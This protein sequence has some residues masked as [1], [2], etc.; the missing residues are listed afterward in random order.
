MVQVQVM[1]LI[2]QMIS[3]NNPQEVM[4]LGYEVLG[5]PLFYQNKYGEVDYYTKSD[6]I[7]DEHWKTDIVE[8]GIYTNMLPDVKN[9]QQKHVEEFKEAGVP[10]KLKDDIRDAIN[11]VVPLMIENSFVGVLIVTGIQFTPK[12]NEFEEYSQKFHMIATIFQEKLKKHLKDNMRVHEMEHGIF[13]RILDGI[14][15]NQKTLQQQIEKIGWKPEKY[16]HLMVIQLRSMPTKGVYDLPS[17]MVELMKNNKHLLLRYRGKLIY[18]FSSK[19]RAIEHTEE[20]EELKAQLKHFN[21]VV[22][23]SH[24]FEN[25]QMLKRY[26]IQ[27]DKALSIGERLMVTN[28][29][30]YNFDYYYPFTLIDLY[31]KS[32][33]IDD[34]INEDIS[35]LCEYDEENNSELAKTLYCYLQSKHDVNLTAEKMYLHRNT[36]RYRIKRCEELLET[37]FAD[38][39]ESFG[40][41]LSF[42]TIEYKRAMERNKLI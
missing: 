28:P 1:S 7:K 35:F 32:E 33:D 42:K 9:S 4:D 30:F 24:V 23:V 25:L 10:I 31:G 17:V 40:H 36:V 14:T 26:Y 41:I 37:D 13:L 12:E 8:G 3:A 16:F 18:I 20:L 15:V 22:G 21:M 27:A 34:L 5:N 11:Y 6:E 29:T 19:V 38:E 2:R 39:N